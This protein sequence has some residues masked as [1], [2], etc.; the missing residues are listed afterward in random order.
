MG[1]PCVVLIPHARY[2][3]KAYGLEYFDDDLLHKC[4]AK[5][6]ACSQLGMGSMVLHKRVLIFKI[7]CRLHFKRNLVCVI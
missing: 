7:E 2:L 3:L 5:W 4:H 1:K 6:V